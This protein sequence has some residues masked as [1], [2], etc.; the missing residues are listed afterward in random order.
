MKTG[1]FFGSF[2]PIHSGH[3]IIASWMAEYTDLEQV[4]LVLSPQNPLK[5]AA[6]LLND[7]QRFQMVELAIGDYKKLKASKV[8]FTLPRPSYTI[9]TLVYL[10]EQYADREFALIMGSDNL[11]TLHKWKNYDVILENYAI[12]I[13][14]RPGFDG[15]QLKDH[16][17]IRFTQ[18]PL[19][20]ISST[21]IRESIK[22][23]KDLRYMMPSAVY[24]YIDEMNFYRR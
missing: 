9:Q 19:M 24:A 16:P 23:G 21:K 18:A 17:N 6:S 5:P 2:N 14:P 13:Y 20:E 8:E 1:L 4:W 10:K 12:Y 7:Y 15:G 11:Q 22:A 3:M